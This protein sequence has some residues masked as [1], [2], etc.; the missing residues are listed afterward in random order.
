M[1][2]TETAITSMERIATHA[3]VWGMGRAISY[4]GFFLR[5]IGMEVTQENLKRVSDAVQ[6]AVRS[7]L[8]AFVKE[9]KIKQEAV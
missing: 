5:S 7:E 4:C 3:V 6:S 9:N 1:I 8:E 2:D